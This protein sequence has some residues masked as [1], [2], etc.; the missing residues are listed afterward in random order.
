MPSTTESEGLPVAQ[1]PSSDN[2]RAQLRTAREFLHEL[3]SSI[4]ERDTTPRQ[5]IPLSYPS[6]L[7][8]RSNT[9]PLPHPV[10]SDPFAEASAFTAFH[11]DADVGVFWHDAQLSLPQQLDLPPTIAHSFTPAHGYLNEPLS[12]LRAQYPYNRSPLRASS[13]SAADI[14]QSQS[15]SRNYAPPYVL[16][17]VFRLSCASCHT[18]FTN[19]GMRVSAVWPSVCVVG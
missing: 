6:S 10:F 19:R 15:L 7:N 13:D 9:T 16:H 2:P 5:L 4:G 12:A 11:R 1:L 8:I 18:F 14:E 17:K 3:Q